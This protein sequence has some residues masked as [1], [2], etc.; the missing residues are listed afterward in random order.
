M[1]RDYLSEERIRAQLTTRW[2]GRTIEYYDEID[3]TN[4]YLRQR[5]PHDADKGYLV[6]A[7]VQTAGR[8]RGNRT[9]FAPAGKCLLWSALLSA[10]MDSI[11]AICAA[12][13]AI[14]E[15]T[16]SL[17]AAPARVK[18]PNDVLVHGRKLA[19]VLAERRANG[20][21]V[22]G[23]GINVRLRDEDLPIA[24]LSRATS[25]LSVTET[26]DVPLR[27]TVLADV[28]ARL[29]PMLDAVLSGQT[30][31]V[32]ARWRTHSDTLG[33]WLRVRT[34]GRIL[35]GVAEDLDDLG[36]LVLR[37]ADGRRRVLRAGEILDAR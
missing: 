14:A 5:R 25:L 17:V 8:G 33:R 29:E 18:W 3:S 32:F 4:T 9:W 6:V 1:E 24:L 20:E 11:A 36:G 21:L 31:G 22:L 12:S 19:G 23:C 13:V 34:G 26:G 16:Q 7:D 2:L 15:M 35:E 37:L 27:A 10:G 28:L 30:A